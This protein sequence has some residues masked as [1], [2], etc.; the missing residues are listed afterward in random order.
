[1]AGEI[2]G[3]KVLAMFVAFFGVVFAVNFYMASKAVGTFPGLVESQPY[4]ASQTFDVNRKAQEALGWTVTPSYDA[5]EATLALSVREAASGLPG[6]VA[7]L[8]VLVGRA[9]ETTHDLTPEFV[10]VGDKF[11]TQIAL[12][13][14]YWVLMIDATAADGTVFRQRQRIFVKG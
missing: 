13:K 11:V 4:I 14:G 6:E 7:R 9:T 2:T 1:M 12:D 10:R 3:R 8:S 5:R